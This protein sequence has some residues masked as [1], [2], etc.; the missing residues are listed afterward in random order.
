MT[1]LWEIPTS[2]PMT[3]AAI[4]FD[5]DHQLSGYSLNLTSTA[6]NPALTHPFLHKWDAIS[7][8]FVSLPSYFP[9]SQDT[10]YQNP[11]TDNT[12]N[13]TADKANQP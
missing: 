2:N 8:E 7:A 10:N 5:N 13:N 11:T 12:N 1:P 9:S 4:N 6:S 3:A